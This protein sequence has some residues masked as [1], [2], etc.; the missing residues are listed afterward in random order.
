MHCL[1]IFLFLIILN[2]THNYNAV[3]LLYQKN[4]YNNI[5]FFFKWNQYKNS[6]TNKILYTLFKNYTIMH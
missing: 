4:Y 3:F 6:T 1:F 2:D 5:V